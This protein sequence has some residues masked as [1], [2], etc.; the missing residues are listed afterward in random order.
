[1]YNPTMFPANASQHTKPLRVTVYPGQIAVGQ[2][3]GTANG[4][5][6]SLST[7]VDTNGVKRM[8]F[9]FTIDG[10]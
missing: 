7:Y 1:M 4:M 9:P 2:L 3:F 8:S 10:L 6:T 5:Q